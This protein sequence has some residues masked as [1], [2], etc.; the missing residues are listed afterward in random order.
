MNKMANHKKTNEKTLPFAG[1]LFL[2][3]VFGGGIRQVGYA[4]DSAEAKD[5]LEQA[6]NN[7][8]NASN[9]SAD[10]PKPDTLYY[11]PF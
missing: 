5:A 2:M 10:T 3:L 6:P 9:Q 7:P 1:L 8:D 11:I 4:F